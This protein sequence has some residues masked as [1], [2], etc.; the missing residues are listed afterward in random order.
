M[1][2]DVDGIGTSNSSN[3]NRSKSNWTCPNDRE[4]MLRAKLET[5]WSCKTKQFQTLH[6]PNRNDKITEQERKTIIDVISRAQQSDEIEKK[7]I[8]KMIE[9]LKNM[10]RNARGDGHYTCILCNESFGFF[11]HNAH[12]CHGCSKLVCNKC[13]VDTINHRNETIWFCKICSEMTEILK[14]SGSSYH[15]VKQQLESEHI[16]M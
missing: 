14:K 16:G 5:G 13:G 12:E 2:N 8:S 7:R 3:V 15:E 11:N 9:R 4:L 10:K 1:A 6:S